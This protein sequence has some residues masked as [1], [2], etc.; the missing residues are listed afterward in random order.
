MDKTSIWKMKSKT[1]F[2]LLE[3][4]IVIIIISF[5]VTVAIAHLMRLQADAEQVVMESTLGVLRSAIGMKVAEHIVRYDLKGLGKYTHVNPIQLLAEMP[6]NYLGELK[7]AEPQ[8]L[9]TGHWYYDT[10]N[11]ALVYLVRNTDRFKGG[12]KDPARAR[13]RIGVVYQDINK[14]GFFDKKI[15]RIEGLRL[16]P[17]EAYTWTD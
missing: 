17:L 3:L 11:V 6:N 7:H 12:L 16:S 4:V 13:F 2:S 14:N 1:G 10:T 8:H 5:L 9:E 15:D